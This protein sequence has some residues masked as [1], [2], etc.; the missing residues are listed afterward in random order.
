[1]C[2][3]LRGV[4]RLRAGQEPDLAGE[5][6]ASQRLPW[7]PKSLLKHCPI[8]QELGL[9]LHVDPYMSRMIYENVDI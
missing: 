3:G 8:A 4:S 5:E 1:M 9:E 7:G 6:H 2:G